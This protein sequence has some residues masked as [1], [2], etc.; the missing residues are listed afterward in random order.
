M[1]Q[2]ERFN[3]EMNSFSF[4]A[5]LAGGVLKGPDGVFTGGFL[6]D[7]RLVEK[8]DV[9]VAF[10]GGSADGHDF[11]PDAVRRGAVLV[12]CGDDSKVPSGVSSI[13]IPDAFTML[14]VM[15]A[16]RLALQPGP[17]E[18]VA[19]TGSVGKTTTRE[20]LFSCLKRNFRVHS[21]GH[22]YNTL[23]GC[24]MAILS[25]PADA[26]I[27]LLEMGANHPGEIG[28]IVARFPP[29]ISLVTEAAA[30]HLEGF[31][32]TEGVV[33][34]K[35]EIARSPRLRRFFYNGDNP[36]LRER[37]S[38]LRGDIR[39]I[40]VGTGDCDYR[41]AAPEFSVKGGEP[42]LT[43][44]LVARGAEVAVKTRAFG[45]HAAYPAAFAMA[46]AMDLGVGGG[47]AASALEDARSLDGRGLIK[48]LSSGAFLIDDTYNANP[49]SMRAVLE[50]AGRTGERRIAV[51]GEML[52]L[53][54]EAEVFHRE[55]A[56][57][58]RCFDRVWLVGKTWEKALPLCEAEGNV[59][60]WHGD[61]KELGR[62]VSGELGK[63][64]F[65]VIK[66]SRG[67]RLD[68]LADELCQERVP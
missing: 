29:T 27:L 36:A 62:I 51:V 22:S 13:K 33:A 40:S 1:G 49:V 58:F 45:R 6:A 57:L 47:A 59:R 66:G 63:G 42:G 60:H 28:E 52:E 64:D 37:A 9:F 7:S 61:L 50:E 5:G 41:I 67:N 10:R 38:L 4:I 21:A 24:S 53:G 2:G 25:L 8:G 46:V 39:K 48:K 43:F 44:T 19:V 65:I 15:A 17:L 18:T 35:M 14:P 56:P 31:G 34:A 20:F 3:L 32:S 23:I 55:L 11:I 26:E 12:I 30:A 68:I 16:R 54:A